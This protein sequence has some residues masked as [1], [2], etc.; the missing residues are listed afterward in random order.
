MALKITIHCSHVTACSLF[1]G[2]PDFIEADWSMYQNIRYFVR[3]K[4]GVLNIT[5][6]AVKQCCVINKSLFTCHLCFV[7]PL[8]DALLCCGTALTFTSG[9]ELWGFFN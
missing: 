7:A 8:A 9:L 3:S 1:S 4:S 2:P 6:S 5:V